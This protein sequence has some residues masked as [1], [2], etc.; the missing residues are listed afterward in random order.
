MA[1][2]IETA[3]EYFLKHGFTAQQS[4]GIV[5]N[6]EQESGVNP[7][8]VQGDG[9]GRGIAQWSLG[10][11]F[12]PALM[13]GNPTVDLGNQLNYVEQELQ[14]NPLYGLAQLKEA[15]TVDQAANI[16][17]TNY[18]KY[19]IKGARVPDAETIYADSLSGSWPSATSGSTTAQDAGVTTPS[20]G[21][22]TSSNGG[23]GSIV[24]DVL[25][26]IIPG[27]SGFSQGLSDVGK[28]GEA[29]GTA[30]GLST[31]EQAQA[32]KSTT[33]LGSI[34]ELLNP[35]VTL[36]NPFGMFTMIMARG[37]LVLFGVGLMVA[38]V[39]VIG[40]GTKAGRETIKGAVD[41]AKVAAVA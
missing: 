35:T 31:Q 10:G 18:E 7:E 34:D 5:G 6:L 24:G 3:F 8:S 1:S 14:S 26:N 12:Y 41:A 33:F 11:R 32:T 40:F 29:I 4:A 27:F 23:F 28:I 15:T 9:P 19:G 20:T 39:A 36:L 30:L 37:G 17:G 21:Q 16:F 13:T 2:N 22:T 25:G 38:G